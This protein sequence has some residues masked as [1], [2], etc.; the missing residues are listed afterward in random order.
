MNLDYDTLK[1]LLR[2]HPACRL[3]RSDHAPL[4]VSFLHR[5]FIAPNKR[6]LPESDLAETLEDELFGL[7]ERLGDDEFP[8]RAR[9]YLDDW[10]HPDKAWLR[11]FYIDDSD[12][13]HFDLM[14]STEKAIAWLG[15]L[16]ARSFIGTESRLLTLFGLL[17]KINSGAETDPAERIE[18]LNR[19][20]LEIEAEIERVRQGDMRV[21]DPTALRD[22]FQQFMEISHGLLT[23]FREV[24]QNFRSLDRRTRERIALRAGSKKEVLDEVL[25]Q[26][27]A[28]VDSDQGKSFG[29][30]WGFLMSPA[31]RKEFNELLERVLALPPIAT[32][33][34]DSRTRRVY[35]DWRDAGEHTQRTVRNLSR[36]LRRFLDDRARLENRRI[37]DILESIEKNAVALR[38]APPEGAV[39]KIAGAAADINLPMERPLYRAPAPLEIHDVALE[40]GEED[41]DAAALLRQVVVDKSLIV[42]HIRRVLQDRPVVTLQELCELRPL[43]HGLTELLT[44]LQVG[45][46]QFNAV[47]EDHETETVSWR[48]ENED[49]Q[50]II[51]E[52]RIPR[53]IFVR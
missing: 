21:L 29:A 14:P 3:L 26:R 23:D 37:M 45:S 49:E 9:E 34:P 50:P 52:A 17:K 7:R 13:P 25:G 8:K 39:A 27:D 16:S 32:M 30:F 53:V 33:N 51:R 4:V 12:E 28:I 43:K 48:I 11:K 46:D 42:G 47:V 22:H 44:Y 15:S 2:D 41:F 38:D 35:Y 10:A 5:A 36:Q 20:K 1:A 18:E 40:L 24:E 6:M 19:R 31:H